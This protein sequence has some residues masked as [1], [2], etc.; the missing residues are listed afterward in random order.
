MAKVKK[1]F[2][3][4]LAV[5]LLLGA[6]FFYFWFYVPYGDGSIKAGRLNNVQHQGY[7]FKTYEGK[8]I[9]SGLKSVEVGKIQSNEFSFSIENEAL[10]KRLMTLAGEE[11]KLHYKEYYGALPWRG[12]TKYI[13]DSLVYV[14]PRNNAPNSDNK[15]GSFQW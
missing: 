14:E 10:A 12:Y 1:I 13:V 4:I 8:L 15:E 11:V 2:I 3:T 6:G 9:Q 5:V 7:I